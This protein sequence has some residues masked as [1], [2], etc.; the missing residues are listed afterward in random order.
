VL[1]SNPKLGS[2]TDYGA[3]LAI[4]TRDL[5]GVSKIRLIMCSYTKMCLSR[6]I[7]NV[8]VRICVQ[9]FFHMVQSEVLIQ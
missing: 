4:V 5:F 8:L 3:R 7:G 1:Y 2:V 9:T 6:I